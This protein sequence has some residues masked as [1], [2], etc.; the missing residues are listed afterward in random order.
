MKA[1]RECAYC[2]KIF[3]QS[4]GNQLYCTKECKTYQNEATQY[5]LYGLLKEFR[6]GFLA[7]FRLLEKLLPKK[8]STQYLLEELKSYGF[9][10]DCYFGAF[11][12][13]NKYSWHKIANYCFCVYV[14]K[15]VL[16]IK[17]VNK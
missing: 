15:N 4:H 10:P 1:K 14:E 11:A 12:D 2:T 13:Q 16:K 9:N 7:N 5:K 6:N 8:G 3:V 17:I